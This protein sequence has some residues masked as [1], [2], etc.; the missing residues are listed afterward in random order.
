MRAKSKPATT[1]Y[2]PAKYRKKN[3]TPSE[4]NPISVR[5]PQDRDTVQVRLGSKSIVLTNLRK[6]FWP[7]AGFT[8][9]DLI[10]FYL[11]ISHVLL[12][13]LAHRAMVMKRYPNG[14]SGDFFFMERS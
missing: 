9:G 1:N 14:I 13:H 10:Q 11:D 2:H 8:K 4:L 5:I 7:D 12:P 6:I 3:R